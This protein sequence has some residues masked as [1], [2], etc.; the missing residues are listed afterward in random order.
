MADRPTCAPRTLGLHSLQ[1]AHPEENEGGL[2]HLGHGS[3]QAEKVG[4]APLVPEVAL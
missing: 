1:P 4:S 3:H 2:R